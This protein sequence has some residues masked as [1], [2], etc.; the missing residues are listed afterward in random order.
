MKDQEFFQDFRFFLEDFIAK[1]NG[2]YNVTSSFFDSYRKRSQKGEY[3]KLLHLSY[4]DYLSGQSFQACLHRLEEEV[5]YP[6]FKQFFSSLILVT[7]EGGDLVELA[8]C[9]H[10]ILLE[11]KELMEDRKAKLKGSKREQSL[12]LVMPL[13]LMGALSSSGFVSKDL[14]FLDILIRC[15]SLL[16]F[17]LA[18]LWSES[19]V[20]ES[21]S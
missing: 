3:Y 15:I 5:D 8:T 7:R 20:K 1:L 2:G 12:M 21:Y 10:Q 11:K 18:W 6:L 17:I 16:F 19:I 4:Q 9:F 13:I 14:T